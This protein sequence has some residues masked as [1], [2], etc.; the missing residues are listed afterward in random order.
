MARLYQPPAI[1]T[2]PQLPRID[3]QVGFRQGHELYVPTQGGVYL[4]HDLRGILY[5]GKSVDLRRRF[6]E[7]YWLGGNPYLAL[8]VANPIGDVTFSWSIA[9]SPMRDELEAHL[10]AAYNPPCNRLKYTKEN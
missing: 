2:V 10:I 5:V 1:L 9:A 3:G 8:A 4:I 7:H 6:A